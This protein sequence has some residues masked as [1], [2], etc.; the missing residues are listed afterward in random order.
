[1]LAGMSALEDTLHASERDSTPDTFVQEWKRFE[2]S[3]EALPCWSPSQQRTLVRAMLPSL[4][5]RLSVARPR[6]RWSSGDFT[7][8]NLCLGS[9]ER[10]VVFDAEYASCTHFFPEETVRFRRI[11]PLCH[12][13]PG[14]L[15]GW[16]GPGD[17]A[18]EVF[19]QLRQ[20]TLEYAENSATYLA[21]NTPAR[22]AAIR[23]FGESWLGPFS[24]DWPVPL[25]P[26]PPA[27]GE[28][29]QLF[30]R[31][32]KESFSEQRSI[33]VAIPIG[34]RQFV[35]FRLPG[36]FPFWR[37]DP[38]ETERTIRLYSLTPVHLAPAVT[39]LPVATTFENARVERHSDHTC[40][41]A[42]GSDP[43]IHFALPS[44]A[45]GLVVDLQCC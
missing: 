37:L 16:W 25:D 39:R 29:V 17:P 31:H 9:N 19:F 36:E 33:R 23:F 38:A 45:L 15:E 21:G 14:L 2:A 34:V 12:R 10:P 6:Q 8:T 32:K 28:I 18:W 5:K 42:V 13:H 22:L 4:G 26:S 3:V 11:S 27:R 30:W 41:R 7:S 35:G 43:Q 24:A 1:M 20:L 40:L 44:T